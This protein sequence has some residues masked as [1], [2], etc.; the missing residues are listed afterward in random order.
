VARLPRDLRQVVA[1]RFFVGMDSTE[2]GAAL[3]IPAVTVRR[4]LQRAMAHLRQS[5]RDDENEQSH[6]SGA[7]SMREAAHDEPAEVPRTRA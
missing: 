1:L 3:D 6:P 5:L 2:I 7:V 4:R